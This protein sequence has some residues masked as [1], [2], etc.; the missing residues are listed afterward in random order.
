MCVV[1]SDEEECV[2]WS[3]CYW[4]CSEDLCS[5]R[6]WQ[7]IKTWCFWSCLSVCVSSVVCTLKLICRFTVLL[8]HTLVVDTQALLY[9]FFS[10]PMFWWMPRCYYFYKCYALSVLSDCTILEGLC[11]AVVM[12]YFVKS[13]RSS[14]LYFSGFV[15]S[16]LKQRSC[17]DGE[18]WTVAF[19]LFSVKHRDWRGST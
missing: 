11:I 15:L 14:R 4:L 3:S 9:L 18:H 10:G 7:R 17:F 1:E 5:G 13:E 6:K 19:L 2:T 12:Q 16:V 8:H